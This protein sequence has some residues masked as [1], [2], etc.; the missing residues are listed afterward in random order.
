V[1]APIL[2][3]VWVPVVE[4]DPDEMTP[5]FQSHFSAS[6]RHP[7]RACVRL[8]SRGSSHCIPL[9][10]GEALCGRGVCV[11]FRGESQV[12]PGQGPEMISR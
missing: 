8:Q 2:G 5:K 12:R 7:L 4:F 1:A 6:A 11:F 10:R 3:N 9:L